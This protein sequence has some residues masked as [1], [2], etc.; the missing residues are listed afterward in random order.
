MY[1]LRCDF[2]MHHLNC[3]NTFLLFY[4]AFLFKA[5]TPKCENN[6]R[7]ALLFGT[8]QLWTDHPQF[9]P[10]TPGPLRPYV[11]KTVNISTSLHHTFGDLDGRNY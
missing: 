4:S 11:E 5:L 9:S 2:Y 10:E 8:G 6:N 7:V 3:F 1:T